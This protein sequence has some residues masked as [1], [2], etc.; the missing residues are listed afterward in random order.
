VDFGGSD[1]PLSA[2]AGEVDAAKARCKGNPAWDLPLVFGPVAISY[3][4]DGVTSPITLNGE[5]IAKIFS[6][7]ITTWNDPA[8]AALNSGVTL[9][10][11]PIKVIYRSDDS[12]TTDNFQQY[13]TAAGK[14]AWTKGAGKKFVGGVGS[15]ADKSA[16]V[17]QAVAGAN[18]GI[19][20][21]ELSFARQ[22]KL[23]IAKIDNGSG[24]VELTDASVGKAIE[25]AQ[26]KGTGNDLVLDL[27]SIYGS[28]TAGAYPL[29]LATYEL[30]C[31]KGYD[32]D[33][34]TAIKAFLTVAANADP[35]R[36][37]SA[38]YAP[39]PAAFKDEV[40]TAIKA[41]A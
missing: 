21:V 10:A 11:T 28:S 26:I 29:V 2:A 19:S 12:G 34:V 27:N 16:G 35:A 41:I 33:V 20:Y 23:S 17:A 6:G 7:A 8:I 31:S 25:G 13:L 37:S 4:L 5:T 39:L 36:L 1:S 24:P 32:P 14:G 22:N 30:V 9:P 18:G 3:K 38:G 15:G 40:V